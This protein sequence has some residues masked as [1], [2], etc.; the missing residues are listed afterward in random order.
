LSFKVDDVIDSLKLYGRYVEASLRSQMQYRT[1]FLMK[2]SAHFMVTGLEFLG[3]AAVFQRFGQIRGW[4]LPQMALFYGIISMS[5]A[6]S[7]AVARGFDIFPRMI[8]AGEF[9]RILLRPRSTAF[10]ILGQELQLMR[11]G[12]FLQGAFVLLWAMWR[13]NVEWTIPH[14]LLILSAIAG[15]VCL[16]SGL[17]VIQAAICFWTTESVEILNCATYGGVDL[18]QF[19]ISIYRPWFR[20]IF[21]YVIPLAA[22]NYFPAH[23]ILSL[24]DPLG[25][26]RLLQWVSPAAGVLFLWLT[27]QFWKFGVRHY[28]STGN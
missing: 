4:T 15:G 3:M 7:E 26:T 12:R 9:D 19:P 24:D 27:L 2:S 5:F 25:S 8:K 20:G 23:A 13:L 1:S 10:Q 14:L 11:I 28:S 6:T 16:F 21:I 17:F 22:V 18:A